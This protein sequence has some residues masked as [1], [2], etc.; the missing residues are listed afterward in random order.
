MTRKGS[1]V[2]VLYG[3]PYRLFETSAKRR[4]ARLAPSRWLRRWA[5]ADLDRVGGRGVQELAGLAAPVAGGSARRE[6]ESA[7]TQVQALRE[8]QPPRSAGTNSASLPRAGQE[9]TYRALRPSPVS[10]ALVPPVRERV[11]GLDP[12][13]TSRGTSKNFS[14]PGYPYQGRLS[15]RHAWRDGRC[16]PGS[17]TR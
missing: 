3:P 4:A 10:E 12:Q 7:L 11:R 5:V 8:S 2:R 15:Q 1:E 6:P 9:D 16:D 13:A 14:R 17:E